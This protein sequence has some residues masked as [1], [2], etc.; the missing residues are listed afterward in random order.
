M[1]NNQTPDQTTELTAEQADALAEIEAE[2]VGGRQQAAMSAAIEA[3][4]YTATALV[5]MS[6][7]LV[8]MG[9]AKGSEMVSAF[10]REFARHEAVTL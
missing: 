10:A 1:S 7:W 5:A 2:E 6:Q 8:E 9:D 3:G 4:N